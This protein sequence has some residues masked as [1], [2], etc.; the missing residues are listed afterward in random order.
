MDRAGDGGGRDGRGV[1]DLSCGAV[2][3]SVRVGAMERKGFTGE[4]VVPS[5]SVDYWL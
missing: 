5:E 4:N 3:G 2:R 1:D